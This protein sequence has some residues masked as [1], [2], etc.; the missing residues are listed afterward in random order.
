MG[1]INGN[2]KIGKINDNSEIWDVF[3]DFFKK[4][5]KV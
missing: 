2:F 5:V 1:S 4:R 3:K